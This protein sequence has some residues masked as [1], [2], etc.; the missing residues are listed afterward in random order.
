MNTINFT[1]EDISSVIGKLNRNEAYGH[2]Q[3]SIRM[4][5]IGDKGVSKPIYFIFAFCI[6]S[7][8]F[9]TKWKMAK[10]VPI[11]K[12]DEKQDV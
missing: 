2:D 4:L 6:E 11:H 12:Q 8:I 7:G 5:Q 9:P 1:E 3:V 10:V